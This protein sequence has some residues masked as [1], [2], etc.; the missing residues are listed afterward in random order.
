MTIPFSFRWREPPG[1]GGIVDGI[2]RTG[3]EEVLISLGFSDRG[4]E[5]RGIVEGI[6]GLGDGAIASGGFEE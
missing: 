3:M 1:A 5:R 4:R 2:A 6:I